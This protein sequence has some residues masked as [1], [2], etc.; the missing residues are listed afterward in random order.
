[1]SSVIRHIVDARIKFIIYISVNT[2]AILDILSLLFFD[3]TF[4][5]YT[6]FVIFN[7]FA[8]ED[9]IIR[10][11]QSLSAFAPRLESLGKCEQL[12]VLEPEGGYLNF[13][14]QNWK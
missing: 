10:F 11:Y 7:Y 5:N 13:L 3:S 12:T 14:N 2:L 4:K 6:V 9:T 1:M 8:F